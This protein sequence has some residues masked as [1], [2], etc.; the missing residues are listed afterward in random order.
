MSKNALLDKLITK[1]YDGVIEIAEYTCQT[2]NKKDNVAALAKN[3][4]S[5]DELRKI[6]SSLLVSL[7]QYKDVDPAFL[8]AEEVV[9]I[10][11]EII[12]AISD[13]DH[14]T[15]VDCT[16]H[17]EQFLAINVR[18]GAQPAVEALAV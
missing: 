17:L 5:F 3:D 11:H 1:L 10:L 7:N 2:L 4:P 9:S 6:C 12:D 14:S 8:Q 13:E 18:K 15:L 16:C